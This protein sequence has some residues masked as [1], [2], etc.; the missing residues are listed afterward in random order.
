MHYIISYVYHQW[1]H[2]PAK[3]NLRGK[4]FIYF[5][6][7]LRCFNQWSTDYI[8]LGREHHGGGSVCWRRP[9][10]SKSA[11]SQLPMR[12]RLRTRYNFQVPLVMSHRLWFPERTQIQ[13]LAEDKVFSTQ[14][15]RYFLFNYN[16]HI[17][18]S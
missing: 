16:M 12:K 18:D 1:N 8:S 13:A 11:G 6:H 14:L 9:C 3:G 7:S 15:W 2:V 5:A 10:P 17:S 4:G